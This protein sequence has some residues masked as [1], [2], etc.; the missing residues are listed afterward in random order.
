M[1]PYI[2]MNIEL[3]KK[4]TIGFEKDL[5][6]LM[7]SS[8]FG[9]TMENLQMRATTKLVRAHEE[10][11]LQ[12]LIGSAA[13]AQANIFDDDLAAIQVHNSTQPSRV[14]RDEHP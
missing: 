4:A 9:K 8:A 13:F 3:R 5:F 11:K 12:C 6:K 10:D 1:E 2:K 14:C 7:N